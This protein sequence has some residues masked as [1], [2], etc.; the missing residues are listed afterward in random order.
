MIQGKTNLIITNS[1]KRGRQ[2]LT[3]EETQTKTSRKQEEKEK[4]LI[5]NY[6]HENGQAYL[7]L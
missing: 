6:H 5:M 7:Q 4:F 1:T 2:P 3:R